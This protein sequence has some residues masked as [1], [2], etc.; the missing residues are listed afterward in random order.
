MPLK[1]IALFIVL[2][3]AAIISIRAFNLAFYSALSLRAVAEI[4][5]GPVL[6]LFLAPKDHR[7]RV[8]IGII[9]FAGLFGVATVGSGVAR[10]LLLDEPLAGSLVRYVVHGLV[11][12]AFLSTFGLWAR[13]RR[14]GRRPD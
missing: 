7:Q 12:I 3:A 1:Q 11:S 4:A 13:S 5:I 10:C 14:H 9:A 2:G 6:A 8:L